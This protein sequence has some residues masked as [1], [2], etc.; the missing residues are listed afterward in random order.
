[1]KRKKI[2]KLEDFK[3]DSITKMQMFTMKGG[4]KCKY[5][6]YTRRC[7]DRM[8]MDGSFAIAYNLVNTF[9]NITD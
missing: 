4:M 7:L 6:M 1:M 2:I 9:E 8:N 5:N 3:Y